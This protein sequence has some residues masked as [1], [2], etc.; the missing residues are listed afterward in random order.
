MSH[1]TGH[2]LPTEDSKPASGDLEAQSRPQGG[3]TPGATS[4]GQ[5]ETDE[6]DAILNH[7]VDM[8]WRELEDGMRDQ[9][10]LKE[11]RAAIERYSRHQT[12]DVTVDLARC[13]GILRG[14]GHPEEGFEKK[15]GIERLKGDPNV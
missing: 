4:G 10:A 3:S 15:Y 12:M 8:S 13:L 7:H 2:N 1:H 11:T 9:E 6:L 14:L 5:T